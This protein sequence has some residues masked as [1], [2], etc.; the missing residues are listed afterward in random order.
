MNSKNVN[1]TIKLK[2][3]PNGK[4]ICTKMKQTAAEEDHYCGHSSVPSQ[5]PVTI[6]IF[7]CSFS[8][9]FLIGKEGEMLV[10]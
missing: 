1:T 6:E 3:K 10:N 4:K 8:V 7:C 2:F 9:F 5:K